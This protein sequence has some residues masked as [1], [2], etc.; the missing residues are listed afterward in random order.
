MLL[1]RAL[2][3]C[4]L[5][6]F[7]TTSITIPAANAQELLNL[8]V[9][10]KAISLSQAYAPTLLNGITVH[11]ENPFR[12]D[13][14][15]STG[16]S[17]LEG[18]SLKEESARLVKYFMTS[19]TVPEQDLWVNLSPYEK[20]RMVPGSFGITWMGRD[21]LAQDYILKELSSSLIDPQKQL[22]KEFWQEVYKAT[23][24]RYGT[25]Q[26][27]VNTFNKIWIVADSAKIYEHGSS[28]YV[29]SCKLRVLMEE[30]LLSMNKNLRSIIGSE[31]TDQGQVRDSSRIS[32]DIMRRI[33]VPAIERE[34]NEGK[35]FANLRQ[36][37]QSLIL[38]TWYKMKLKE[39]L[40]GKIYVGKDKTDGIND[41]SRT[42]NQEIYSR[43]LKAFRKGVFNFIQD[44]IDPVT[45]ASIPRKY[46]SGGLNVAQGV[47]AHGR[48]LPLEQI[49]NV[50]DDKSS[51]A[52]QT[53]QE[54]ASG[55]GNHPLFRLSTAFDPAM[56]SIQGQATALKVI[57]Q[58]YPDTVTHNGE[59][60]PV[61]NDMILLGRFIL[62]EYLGA[63]A[64]DNPKHSL[65][66]NDDFFSRAIDFFHARGVTVGREKLLALLGDLRLRHIVD[67]GDETIAAGNKID[68]MV[69]PRQLALWS[70]D[71]DLI[72]NDLQQALN[73]QKNYIG[74]LKQGPLMKLMGE[75]NSY[76]EADEFRPT[77]AKSP[78]LIAFTLLAKA[79]QDDVLNILLDPKITHLNALA[80][81]VALAFAADR[82]GADWVLE[83]FPELIGRKII[84][85]TPELSTFAGG[86]GRV[87]KFFTA[88]LK[89]FGLDVLVIEG[90]YSSKV[91]L[92][93]GRPTLESFDYKNVPV[94]INDLKDGKSYEIIYQGRY[95]KVETSEGT[96]V[97]QVPIVQLGDGG[98][99]QPNPGEDSEKGLITK[100]LYAYDMP[101]IGVPKSFV[102]F[103]IF[104]SK[105]AL[106]YIIMD[107]VKDLR[108]K[109]MEH[110][111]APV[112]FIQDG[113]ALLTGFLLKEFYIDRDPTPSRDVTDPTKRNL[114]IQDM[115][116]V[117]RLM[118]DAIETTH[119]YFNTGSQGDLQG[120]RNRLLQEGIKEEHLHYFLRRSPWGNIALDMS[121]PGLR[122]G[123]PTGVAAKH[124]YDRSRQ[125]FKT[126][127][128]ISNG[129][130]LDYSGE[131]FN[132]TLKA[133]YPDFEGEYWE[134]T[135]DMLTAIKNEA[136]K[137]LSGELGV[138]ISPDLPLIGM[139]Q[140]GVDEKGWLHVF[141]QDNVLEAIKKGNL[142][143]LVNA[144]A[145]DE[146]RKLVDTLESIRKEAD[147]LHALDPATY[148]GRFIVRPYDA[149][150]QRKT[151]VALD[152]QIH[153]PKLNTGA[154]EMTETNV[155]RNGGINIT[156][157]YL[158]GMVQAGIS[159]R[160]PQK[161][162]S[163]RIIPGEYSLG[164]TL[165]NNG[166]EASDWL[167]SILRV[168]E[169]FFDRDGSGRSVLGEAQLLALQ[170]SRTLSYD[171]TTG[172]Y[173][174]LVQKST[175]S[176]QTELFRRG[177]NGEVSLISDQT[178]VL[179]YGRE[180]SHRGSL[181]TVK[182]NS[183]D[184][185][186]RIAVNLNATDVFDNGKQGII[187]E[188]LVHA[189][190]LLEGGHEISFTRKY[191]D[192]GHLIMEAAIPQGQ[193]TVTGKIYVNSGLWNLKDEDVP[194]IRIKF[195]KAQ[196]DAA[197]VV[198]PPGGILLDPTNL[199][200][201]VQQDDHGQ[202]E[203]AGRS[204]NA[205]Q[206]TGCRLIVLH[207]DP[208]NAEQL[209]SLFA[210]GQAH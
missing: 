109:G 167:Y 48:S 67:G 117:A 101:W 203:M 182:G 187:D 71:V 69:A 44:D 90:R 53:V 115:K 198:L 121:S 201:Q 10:G 148:K 108:E 114:L 124:A 3:I 173:L 54:V 98:W 60:Y 62:S 134:V 204:L 158:E 84:I 37:Y 29:V 39:S 181:F 43:Y 157:A 11:P 66:L 166:D 177:I 137:N 92:V 136:K 129:D 32:S 89:K 2:S 81:A 189:T 120:I 52:A 12:L 42:V 185:A 140:R 176:P 40:L 138:E 141:T 100:A 15:I 160:L 145:Y 143:A 13:F 61:W 162:L 200:M 174:R 94:Q 133:L 171:V 59:K 102:D 159:F 149:N 35:N 8:P 152:A 163:E 106:D 80:D 91:K 26:M 16:D 205:D 184:I 196:V 170:V 73:E 104:F 4:V 1:R 63:T 21:L 77:E 113:Q 199:K 105:S 76:I 116:Y 93:D 110:F 36:V 47:D 107:A 74:D 132:K 85:V 147:R 96:N 183:N 49:I 193:G 190:L 23:Q 202:W 64:N 22:G 20:N 153:A 123:I 168:Q 150:L 46:F 164:T 31:P 34:V 86:L 70:K 45:M 197:Q 55:L 88:S 156:P 178:K 195:E 169:L 126:V 130:F 75:Y 135:R 111:R 165:V 25:T 87:M 58:P 194:V 161:P 83:R 186:V 191:R 38:A 122:T 79:D 128:G 192:N 99:S 179:V 103:S 27:P 9:P 207:L 119:T 127:V 57:P 50:V 151:L 118:Y 208:V 144:Q 146:S 97:D 155:L 175:K 18:A 68:L 210:V 14:L 41:N 188:K 17:N 180:V 82:L 206:F 5:F 172:D 139:A 131:F 125:E 19:L 7:L 209:Q 78:V 33:I 51:D 56:G 95:R 24:Q 30:D 6:S 65:Y 112:L 154:N 72:K 28:A 142:I